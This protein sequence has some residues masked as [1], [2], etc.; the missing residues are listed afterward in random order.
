MRG[1]PNE[2]AVNSRSLLQILQAFASYVEVPEQHLQEKRAAPAFE[3]A[4]EGQRDVGR[5]HSGKSKP[6]SAYVAVQYRGY[7]FWLDDSD[8][9]SKRALTTVMF[10][11]TLA[12]TGNPERLPLVTIPAQ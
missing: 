9:Q 8:W 5:I 3:H 4:A 11:F 2:L 10:F 6:D 7:W 12:D 1:A